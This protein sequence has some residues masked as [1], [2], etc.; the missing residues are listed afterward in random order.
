MIELHEDDVDK[1]VSEFMASLG[2]PTARSLYDTMTEQQ[3][4]DVLDAKAYGFS[5]ADI[6]LTARMVWG[7]GS[8]TT[9]RRYYYRI[10]AER[11]E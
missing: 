4:Q 6:G 7:W 10:K 3:K 1:E 11:G 2:E 8:E 5:F 9:L